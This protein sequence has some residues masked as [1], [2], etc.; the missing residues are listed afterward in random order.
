LHDKVK[1][2]KIQPRKQKS[3]I[4]GCDIRFL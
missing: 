4:S 3:D 1:A 2:L